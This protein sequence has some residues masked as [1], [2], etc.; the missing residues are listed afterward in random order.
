MDIQ[1]GSIV[2]SKAGRDKQK[3]FLVVGTENGYA[4]LADGVLRRVEKPKKKKFMHL[5]KTNMIAEFERE[6]LTNAAVRKI[7]VGF[8]PNN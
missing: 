1:A 6:T 3:M 8:K 4:L 2:Y 7:L 5:Q